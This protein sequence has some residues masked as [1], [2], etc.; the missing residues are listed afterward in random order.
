MIL[1]SFAPSILADST[2]ASGTDSKAL[3]LIIKNEAFVQCGMMRAHLV[4]TRPSILLTMYNGTVPP[5]K[6]I[7]KTTIPVK[8]GLILHL[9]DNTYPPIMFM[10]EPNATCANTMTIVFTYPIIMELSR[11]VSL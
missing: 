8:I 5:V 10:K 9:R 6:I 11:K 4:P 7:V 3:T 1:K 2:V